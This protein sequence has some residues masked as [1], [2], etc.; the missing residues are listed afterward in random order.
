MLKKLDWY[1]IKKYMATFFFTMI[2]ITM[3]AV[4]INFSEN[5]GKFLKEELGMKE[6]FGDY[7]LNFIPWI[8]GKLWPLFALISVIFFTSR[9]AKNSE[10]IAILSA[11]VSYKR[12]LVPFMVAASFIAGL[13]WFGNNFV[14]PKSNRV[15]ND[16]ES[17]YINKSRNKLRDRTYHAFINPNEKV[18]INSWIKRD[19]FG[20]IFRLEKFKDGQLHEVIKA[21]IIRFKEAPN[22]WTLENY[23]R[24]VFN[25]IDESYI[26]Y[27]EATL[28]TIIDLKPEDFEINTHEME[29]MTSD[30]LKSFIVRERARGLGTANPHMVELHRRSADPFTIIILTL[31]GVALASRKV[32]GGMGLHLAMGIIL[33]ASFVVIS[34]F[35]V[36]FS[37][38]LSLSPILGVWIPN[39]LFLAIGLVLISK[40]QQ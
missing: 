40:A 2:M 38:N 6:I 5:V 27:G 4:V 1:I 16:F 14:I 32:R 26:E 22:V 8:N 36:T 37:N 20:N 15:K 30:E 13:L 21:N 7:Y 19:T 12:F 25:G 10:I 35:T 28:D 24:R 17:K 39:I 18:F 31:I 3:I 23:K 34:Q 11:G 9:L 33:G 29:T